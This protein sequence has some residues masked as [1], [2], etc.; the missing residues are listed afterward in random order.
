M[1]IDAVRY[2]LE[3]GFEWV[4]NDNVGIS[5]L[6]TYSALKLQPYTL[7]VTFVHPGDNNQYR[8]GNE[9]VICSPWK[10]HLL[11]AKVTHDMRRSDTIC[12]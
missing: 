8:P 3:Q 12:A 9:S 5:T 1:R 2:R 11:C 4:S 7:E 6:F 10:R